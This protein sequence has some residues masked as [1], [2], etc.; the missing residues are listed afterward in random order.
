MTQRA[1]ISGQP[2]GR[3]LPGWQPPPRPGRCSLD[4]RFCRTEPLDV[5]RHARQFYDASSRDPQVR[6]WTCL[7]SGPCASFDEYRAWLEPGPAS[8]DPL[9][10]ALV[11]KGRAQAV[12]TGT[13]MRIDAANGFV[14]GG[15]PAF[16]PPMQRT[17]V[18]TAAMYLMMR[19]AFELRYGRCEWKCDALDDAC[20]AWLDPANFDAAGRQRVSPVGI[21]ISQTSSD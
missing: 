19:N 3:A 7:C 4:R 15:H 5:A 6:M 2:T 10:F 20:R 12:G 8:E 16:S 18:A 13:C 9:F 11:D 1:D 17:P 14:E 21:R